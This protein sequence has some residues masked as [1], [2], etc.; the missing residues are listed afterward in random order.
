MKYPVVAKVC[1][2]AQFH[3]PM[4]RYWVSVVAL[5]VKLLVSEKVAKS[6]VAAQG[7]AAD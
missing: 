6:I 2:S 5:S 3:W 4:D 1:S 7:I